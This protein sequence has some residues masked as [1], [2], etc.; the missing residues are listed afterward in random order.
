ME[1]NDQVYQLKTDK[2]YTEI[3]EFVASF[4]KKAISEV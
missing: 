1:E 4:N 3:L 2:N